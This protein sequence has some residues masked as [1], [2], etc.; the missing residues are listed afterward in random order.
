MERLSILPK[1]LLLHTIHGLGLLASNLTSCKAGEE[2]VLPWFLWDMPGYLR[3]R[4]GLYTMIMHF[5]DCWL[6]QPVAVWSNGYICPYFPAIGQTSFLFH[7]LPFFP[8][9]PYSGCHL[10]T[11]PSLFLLHV[12]H[13]SKKLLRQLKTQPQ[14]QKHMDQQGREWVWAISF[15]CGLSY[16]SRATLHPRTP[17]IKP[18]TQSGLCTFP[19]FFILW[20]VST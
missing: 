13:T 14:L 3:V 9:D 1:S 18:P 16:L 7:R 4:F 19:L 20:K 15:G 2:P 12:S 6:I 11:S 10:D 8:W 5:P 17:C